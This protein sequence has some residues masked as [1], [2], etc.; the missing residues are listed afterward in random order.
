MRMRSYPR[1]CTRQRR[2]TV[3]GRVELPAVARWVKDGRAVIARPA[4]TGVAVL[5]Q[6]A[7]G[8]RTG[9]LGLT[10]RYGLMCSRFVPLSLGEF[11][12]TFTALSPINIPSLGIS[13]S[14]KMGGNLP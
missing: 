4:K 13:L 14:F 8:W 5:M 2:T 12:Q 3:R 10:L 9:G 6:W 11:G 7:S 1:G